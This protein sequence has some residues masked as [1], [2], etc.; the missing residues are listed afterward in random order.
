MGLW[1]SG[2]WTRGHLWAVRWRATLCRVFCEFG[3]VPAIWWLI[4]DTFGWWTRDE[5]PASLPC[6]PGRRPQ[7]GESA[8]RIA[9][10]L[11]FGIDTQP[12]RWTFWLFGKLMTPSMTPVRMCRGGFSAAGCLFCSRTKVLLVETGANGFCN[13]SFRQLDGC[14]LCTRALF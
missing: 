10:A 6:A 8:S 14:G 1:D 4:L 11:N 12:R 5:M 13:A 2:V 3:G 7:K 9:T